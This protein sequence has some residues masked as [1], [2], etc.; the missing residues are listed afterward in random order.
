[1]ENIMPIILY[2]AAVLGWIAIVIAIYLL[3]KVKKE[4]E[5]IEDISIMTKEQKGPKVV[6][7][8]SINYRIC[9]AF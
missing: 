2:I 7:I 9:L 6:V 8:G 3:Y 4:R 5:N 1:V